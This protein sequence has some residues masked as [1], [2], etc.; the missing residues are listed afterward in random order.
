MR[1]RAEAMQMVADG[2]GSVV[3][4][5]RPRRAGIPRPPEPGNATP[6]VSLL[7]LQTQAA[8]GVGGDGRAPG[9]DQVDR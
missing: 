9:R 5:C 2:F 6:A 3:H 7:C 4:T 8:E 1:G